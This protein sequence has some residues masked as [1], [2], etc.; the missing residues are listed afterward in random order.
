LSFGA[1]FKK[2]CAKRGLS[3]ATEMGCECDWRGGLKEHVGSLKRCGRLKGG[4]RGLK[5]IYEMRDIY[6]FTI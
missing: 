4:A 5:E 6:F 2:K 3:K 1:L